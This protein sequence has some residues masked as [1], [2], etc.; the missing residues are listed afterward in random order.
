MSKMQLEKWTGSDCC[1]CG[2]CSDFE[3]H[4][5][6]NGKQLEALKQGNDGPTCLLSGARVMWRAKYETKGVAQVSW[7]LVLLC[8]Q[9]RAGRS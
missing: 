9:E 3:P 2:P 6:I 7:C 1:A 4:P 8:T 5:E